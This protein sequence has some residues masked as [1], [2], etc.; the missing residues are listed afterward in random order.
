MKGKLGWVHA[1]EE[2][3]GAIATVLNRAAGDAT[4]ITPVSFTPN[5]E[6]DS[7][8]VGQ[9]TTEVVM[10]LPDR[11]V[12]ITS[13]DSSHPR[14]ESEGNSGF[15]QPR[16][17]EL[18]L[19]DAAPGVPAPE[20]ARASVDE[21]IW[22]LDPDLSALRL[23]GRCEVGNIDRNA[24]F[25]AAAKCWERGDKFRGFLLE[26]AAMARGV[27]EKNST[28][29]EW[30]RLCERIG[31]PFQHPFRVRLDEWRSA[32]AG[33]SVPFTSTFRWMRLIPSEWFPGSEQSQT[34]RHESAPASTEGGAP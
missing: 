15:V 2:L 9:F 29:A 21:F 19:A 31:V 7:G 27:K 14:V 17:V 6:F 11:L 10:R 18:R 32:F 34:G 28:D 22:G 30:I 12:R 8:R 16:Q 20:S 26:D 23:I 4:E 24:L 1:S 25:G 5:V 33:Q 13:D 3:R